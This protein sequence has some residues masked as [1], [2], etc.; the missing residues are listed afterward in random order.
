MLSNKSHQKVT[1]SSNKVCK[2]I[3]FIASNKYTVYDY[4]VRTLFSTKLSR[5]FQGLSRKHF[6]PFS[7]TPRGT[8]SS[9]YNA[10]SDALSRECADFRLRLEKL[11]WIKLETNFKYFPAPTAVFKDF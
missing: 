2:F 4:R 1:E 3:D 10:T 9:Q 7:R 11:R 8:K 6:F 5:T